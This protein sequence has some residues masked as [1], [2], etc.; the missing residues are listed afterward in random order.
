MGTLVCTF[1]QYHI[2]QTVPL[3]ARPSEVESWVTTL[4]LGAVI[5]SFLAWAM[6]VPLP[7]DPARLE[8]THEGVVQLGRGSSLVAEVRWADLQEVWTRVSGLAYFTDARTVVVGTQGRFV[9]DG[10]SLGV[11]ELMAR[12]KQLPGFDEE[13]YNRRIDFTEDGRFCVW[14]CEQA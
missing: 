7:R 9:V 8:I 3:E 12:L 11:A 4:G 2:T 6:R 13:A 5:T 1:G 10:D 14:R